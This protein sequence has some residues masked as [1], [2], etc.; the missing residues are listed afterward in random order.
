MHTLM[1]V[2][3]VQSSY[4]SCVWSAPMAGI[5]NKASDMEGKYFLV[6]NF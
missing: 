3:N 1:Q 5:E 4:W 6:C 2:L